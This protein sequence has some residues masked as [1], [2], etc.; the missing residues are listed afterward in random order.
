LQVISYTEVTHLEDQEEEGSA[1]GSIAEKTNSLQNSAGVQP[2]DKTLQKHDVMDFDD[3]MDASIVHAKALAADVNSFSA[4]RSQLSSEHRFSE[5]ES[6]VSTPLVRKGSSIDEVDIS[7]IG[8]CDVSVSGH[9]SRRTDGEDQN[10]ERTNGCVQDGAERDFKSP[11]RSSNMSLESDVES[12]NSTVTRNLPYSVVTE[13]NT[14]SK[15]LLNMNV[16]CQ[17][18]DMSQADLSVP[19][20][21]DTGG[22][23]NRE[24]SEVPEDVCK[25]GASMKD[26]VDRPEKT[27]DMGHDDDSDNAIFDE[28]K[29]RKKALTSVKFKSYD[30]AHKKCGL[31]LCNFPAVSNSMFIAKVKLSLCL[32][33]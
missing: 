3:I 14:L 27:D 30:E 15:Q 8:N 10:Y 6:T 2:L 18:S 20:S 17:T 1:N 26:D 24:L 12:R 21:T 7:T 28:T 22:C 16:S 11:N 4:V 25:T 5:L 13:G 33:K 31:I 29:K 23:F 32:M 19:N 9:E